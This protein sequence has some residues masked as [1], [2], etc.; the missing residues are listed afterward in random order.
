MAKKK[1]TL[2]PT[3]TIGGALAGYKPVTSMQPTV[4][5]GGAPAGY[6]ETVTPNYITGAGVVG[7]PVYQAPT[8]TNYIT[9]EKAATPNKPP[10]VTEPTATTA[11]ALLE[12][13]LRAE[14]IPNDIIQSSVAFLEALDND[15]IDDVADMVSIYFNNKDFTTKSGTKLTSPFYQRYTSLGEGVTNPATGRPYTGKEMFAWRTGIE[16]KVDQYNLSAA[17][18]TDDVLKKLAK[19]GR[20]VAS[21]DE[22]AQTAILAETEADPFKVAA[23]RKMK[24][25]GQDKGL[26]DFYLN[27]EIGQQQLEENRRTGAIATEALRYADKGILFDEARIKQIGAA[28]GNVTEAAAQQKAAALY[29]TVGE[30]LQPMVTLTGIYERPTKTTT[31]MA[32]DIQKE[33]EN[34]TLYSM[35][36]ERRKRVAGLNIAEFERRAGTLASGQGNISL[37]RSSTTGMI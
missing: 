10:V 16:Q 22:L 24:Y 34:E 18:K 21:F 2:Q 28:Y 12:A 15:G 27:P 20:S 36:S 37:S 35:P 4:T 14:G 31:E 13:A 9:G 25:L 11:R 19:S 8:F 33:L 30:S 32:P 17:F 23:L 6:R 3:V 5:I 26:R 29:Q 7:S 1:S